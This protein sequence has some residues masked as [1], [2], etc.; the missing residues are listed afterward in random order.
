M[1]RADSGEIVVA[2]TPRRIRSVQDAMALGMGYVPEERLVQG[3]FMDHSVRSN[4][5]VT[6]LDKLLGRLGLLDDR[7][8]DGFVRSWISE[9]GIKTPSADCP[10]KQLSGGNQQ[11]VVLSKWMERAPRILIMDGPTVGIDVKAKEEIHEIMR[12][13]ASKGMG[14]IMIS[15]E[16]AEIAQHT[17]RLLLM[18]SGRIVGEYETSR[19]TEDGLLKELLYT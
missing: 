2:G 10:V 11:R 4:L 15:D 12:T 8:T 9:L 13:L 6:V 18:K 5:I 7:R 17:N 1:N 3:L 14:V 19:I 16:V